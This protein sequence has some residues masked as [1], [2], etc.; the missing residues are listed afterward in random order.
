MVTGQSQSDSGISPNNAAGDMAG[1][2]PDL[3]PLFMSMQSSQANNNEVV[4]IL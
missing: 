1:V 2:P 4:Q 3:M